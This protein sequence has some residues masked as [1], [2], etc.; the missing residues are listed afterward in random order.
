MRCQHAATLSAA[1]LIAACGG[2]SSGLDTTQTA[3]DVLVI[4]GNNAETAARAS[5]D[6]ALGSADLTDLGDGIGLS[7]G[8]FGSFSKASPGVQVSGFLAGVM[9]TIP[10]GPDVFPCTVSG[11]ITIS[12]NIENP[13]T[14]TAGDDFLVESTACDDGLG[15][16]VDGSLSFMVT[17]FS[18]DVL[19]GLYSVSMDTVV[20]SLQVATADDT[21]SNRGDAL[22]TLDTTAAPFVSASVSGNAMTT[23]SNANTETLSNYSSTQTLDAGA[24]QPLYTMIASG[25]L[26]TTQL[27]GSVSYTTPLMFEGFGQ[28][29]PHTGELLISGDN[30]SARLIA[31]DN[32]NVRIEVDS[33]NDGTVDETINTTWA[34]LST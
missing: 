6:A 30:S 28:D 8:A 26:Q 32:V 2:G 10:F 11:T 22:I 12:G 14:L 5:Y 3:S 24:N 27:S 29:Y 7:A 23:D 16:V 15:E 17:E 33:D 1:L 9:Q 4:S 13:W 19:S 21:I 25:T 34:D 20:D 18:G 31:V